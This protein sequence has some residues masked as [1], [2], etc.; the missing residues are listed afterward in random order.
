MCVFLRSTR[1][2]LTKEVKFEGTYNACC[3]CRILDLSLLQSGAN[4][5]ACKTERMRRIPF[6]ARHNFEKNYLFSASRQSLSKVYSDKASENVQSFFKSSFCRGQAKLS[7][8]KGFSVV[9]PFLESSHLHLI[10]LLFFEG[11][12]YVVLPSCSNRVEY[13]GTFMEKQ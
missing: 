10:S 11:L 13:V 9:I 6:H 7:F 2:L 1:N 4:W 12:P 3:Y 8:I 5:N